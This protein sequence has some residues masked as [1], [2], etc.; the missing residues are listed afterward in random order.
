MLILRKGRPEAAAVPLPGG[1]IIHVRPATAFE[2]DLAAAGAGRMLAALVDGQDA[3]AAA[4]EILGD[5]F[6][7][8]D[9]TTKAWL[10]AA[11]QRLALL[12]L[13]TACCQRW[14]GIADE[15]G[16]LIERPERQH[17]ALLLRDTECAR[18]ISEAIRTRVHDE[19]AEGNA[20][21]ASPNG[22]A[23]AAEAIAPNAAA[24]TA[25]A[26]TDGADGTASAVPK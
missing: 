26:P 15:T 11:A 5:E 24:M 17:L 9:F 19:V 20:S 23:K 8:A 4:L 10:E 25:P 18:R 14:E 2:V 1:A 13:A 16:A 7:H 3:A 12:E 22:A 6:R 21:A